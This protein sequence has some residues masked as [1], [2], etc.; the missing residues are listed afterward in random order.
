MIARLAD[1]QLA[2]A[3]LPGLPRRPD[4]AM[5][6]ADLSRLQ[7]GTERVAVPGIGGGGVPRCWID[8]RT[9]HRVRG[10]T[11]RGKCLRSGRPPRPRATSHCFR[12]ASAREVSREGEPQI[13]GPLLLALVTTVSFNAGVAPPPFD[14][15]GR[16]GSPDR[17]VRSVGRKDS[18][19]VRPP[20]GQAVESSE[21]NADVM[22]DV[23]DE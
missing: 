20:A 13:G 21:A 2:A 14:Q 15:F 23:V 5:K 18:S 8:R 6:V 11:R 10:E 9:G 1:A 16:C 17:S 7:V 12:R 19:A 4:S 22:R 3:A